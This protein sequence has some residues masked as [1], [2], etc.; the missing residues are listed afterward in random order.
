MWIVSCEKDET[1]SHC[2][3]ARNFSGTINFD[4][5]TAKCD[6][7]ILV[8]KCVEC[9]CKILRFLMVLLQKLESYAIS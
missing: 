4:R 2:V 7:I 5:V 9:E 8:D 6:L 1:I 3:D